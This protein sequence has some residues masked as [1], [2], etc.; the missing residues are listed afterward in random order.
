MQIFFCLKHNDH[1]SARRVELVSADGDQ[2]NQNYV[3]PR[4]T[5]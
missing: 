4:S 5:R 1:V 2:T 3:N